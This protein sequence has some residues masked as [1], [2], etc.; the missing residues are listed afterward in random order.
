MASSIEQLV[1]NLSFSSFAKA[2]DLKKR[3]GF[4]L[5]A[6]II[7]RLGT[8]I[9]LPGINPSIIDEFARSHSSGLLGVL[10][11]FSGGAFVRMTVFALNIMPYISASIIV[12]LMSTVIP[13]LETLRKDGESGRKVLNQYTRYGTVGLAI[14]QAFGVSKFLQTQVPDAVFITGSM[15][16]FT[17]VLTLTGGTMFVVWLGEQITSRGIGNGSSLIIF[18]GIV[19]NLP[20]SLVQTLELGKSGS[21]SSIK[22]FLAIFS[23]IAILGY[24]CLFEKAQRRLPIQYPKRQ[25]AANMPA[26]SQTSHLPLKINSAGVIPPIF[27][28]SILLLPMTIFSFAKD[29]SPDTLL[30]K[31]TTY[32]NHG[33]P[34]YMV[35]Y[36]ALI[37]FFAFFY[38]A[39]M[40]NPTETADN[41]RKSSGYIPG[42]RPGIQ[43]AEYIDYVMTRITVLGSLYL[44]SI[45]LVPEFVLQNI[46]LP[47]FF[48]GTSILIVVSTTIDIIGQVQSHLIAHQYEGLIRK[49]KAKGVLKV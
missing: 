15:F 25:V 20:I 6:L 11:L 33:H 4:T 2:E 17:T 47:V 1:N 49:A 46:S 23:V 32:L 37:I 10:N 31:I 19:A 12:Q 3:I 30:S 7:Y 34:V 29:A 40:F 39:I 18:A 42:Y 21:V 43:T 28:S 36:S 38:T 22:I 24:V 48:S 45:C 26:Q 5:L 35:L 44:V 14:V 9:T 8:F 41:L 13:Q 27:A 16:E